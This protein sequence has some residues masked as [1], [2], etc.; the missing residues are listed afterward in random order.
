MSAYRIVVAFS[1][2]QLDRDWGEISLLVQKEQS[3]GRGNLKA[4]ETNLGDT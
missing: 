3:H 1:L 4:N 2:E